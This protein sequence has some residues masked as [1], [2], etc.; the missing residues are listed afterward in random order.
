MWRLD[1]TPEAISKRITHYR[2]TVDE[3]L[4]E[5]EQVVC[6]ISCFGRTGHRVEC[7]S[8]AYIR[9][10]LIPHVTFMLDAAQYSNSNF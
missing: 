7:Y 9:A 6:Y 4:E 8:F 10:A 2:Q 3:I 1:D 5:F